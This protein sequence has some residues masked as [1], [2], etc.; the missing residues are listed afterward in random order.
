MIVSLNWLRQY[1]AVDMP[2]KEL[3]DKFSMIGLNVEEAVEK[4]GDLIIEL[5][6]TSNRGDCL[7]HIGVAREL[8]AATGVEL[9]IPDVDCATLQDS[10]Q[11]VA[12][13]EVLDGELC[14]RY[15][16]RVIRGV[17]IGDSPDWLKKRLESTGHKSISNIVDIT[18]FVMMECGQPL[19]A[20]DLDKL[21]ESRIIVRR[22][23]K[24]E[25]IITI[26]ATECALS[27]DM[28]VIA[29]A[30]RAVAIAGVMGGNDTEVTD[31]TT[32]ILLES[33]AFEPVNIRRTSRALKLESDSSMR[34]GR[35]C[36]WDG[37]EWASR[38]A[39]TL[40]AEIAGGEI[41]E[42][43][44]DVR[45][46]E[47]EPARVVLR[48]EQIA[49]IIGIDV[50]AEDAVAILKSL[51]FEIVSQDTASV[52]VLVPSH[53]SRDVRREIDLI[54]E[55]ARHYGYEKINITK[56]I[57]VAITHP[58]KRDAVEEMLLNFLVARGYSETLTT[59]FAGASAAETVSFWPSAEPLVLRNPVN[60]R[61]PAMRRSLLP[62]LLASAAHNEN[63]G[64]RDLRLFEM[65]TVYLSK[66][67]QNLPEE[68]EVL[69]ILAECDF[70]ELKG[71][72]ET[73]IARLRIEGV[74]FEAAELSGFAPGGA[75]RVVCGDC[76]LGAMGRI[77]AETAKF[78]DLRAKYC[79]AELDFLAMTERAAL[80][81]KF[82]PLPRF[83][84]IERDIAIVVDDA[85]GWRNVKE[86]VC[87]ADAANLRSV[88]FVDIYQ[89]KQ[90]PKGKK[91]LAFRLVY[92]SDEGTLTGEEVAEEQKK[93]IETLKEKVGAELRR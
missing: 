33:A 66:G 89:G 6:V 1:C 10:V 22:A 5:E 87:A 69:G 93:V 12:G 31:S 81:P 75:A 53:R 50:P 16:A 32:N 42:G 51:D 7:S 55:V 24:G 39:A 72:V 45:K 85:V 38:R 37:I 26:D 54:E 19:H 21:N 29:D 17:K 83:P 44:I 48:F 56:P 34:F 49:R 15:T 78:F 61:Q 20:F 79:F 77:S 36:A 11:S 80:N 59:P 23:K 76:P 41:L 91:S 14:P 18:N 67:E 40:I 84:A 27:Q 90:L 64:S 52:E 73:L 28:L 13:V 3:L 68:K 62:S 46:A 88:D 74:D 71:L 86:T 47:Y 60:A 30:S 57:P 63:H 92:R 35:G 43:A 82:S 4:D 2:R 25:K 65:S 8:A 70:S 9:K 58:R